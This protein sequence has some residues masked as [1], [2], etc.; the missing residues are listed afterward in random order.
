MIRPSVIGLVSGLLVAGALVHPLLAEEPAVSVADVLAIQAK[1]PNCEACTGRGAYAHAG[2]ARVIAG[3]IA[4]VARTRGDA[5]DLAVYA[6]F[7]SGAQA[8]AVGDGGRSLGAWQLQRVPARLAFEPAAAARVWLGVAD[9]SRALCADLP[10]AERLAALVSGSC[11]RGRTK[12]RR[13]DEIA[14]EA[15]AP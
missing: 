15:C 7:E 9:A 14:R 8:L 1:V 3:A 11:A 13:R 4:Q 2:D 12:A 6:D 10:A 5:C